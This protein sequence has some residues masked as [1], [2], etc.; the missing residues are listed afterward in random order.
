MTQI[1]AI[2]LTAL[3]AVT[4]ILFEAHPVELYLKAR[5]A[6]AQNTV[7]MGR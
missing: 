6:E 2:P 7:R 5:A 4:N 3:K 1:F